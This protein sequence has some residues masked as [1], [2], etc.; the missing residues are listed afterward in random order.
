MLIC[1]APPNFS[2]MISEDAYKFR[3]DYKEKLHN[4]GS[5]E[6]HGLAYTTYQFM[7]VFGLVKV[8]IQLQ[9][10]GFSC[11]DLGQI[12]WGLFA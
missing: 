4:I 7:D 8:F 2:G 10:F 11:Y 1:L 3:I 5:L 6:S 12:F 9:A